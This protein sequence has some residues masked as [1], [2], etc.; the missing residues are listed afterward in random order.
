MNSCSIEVDGMDARAWHEVLTRFGDASIDQSVAYAGARWPS[1]HLSHLIVRRNA[2]LA[3]AA[4]VVIWR[5]PF[6]RARFGLVKF[7][8]LWRPAGERA[9]VADLR[10]IVAALHRE[11]VAEQGILLRVIPRPDAPDFPAISDALTSGGFHLETRDP[12]PDRYLVDLAPPLEAIEAGLHASWRRHLHRARRHAP[13]V[14]VVNGEDGLARFMS[15]Y[16][17]MRARKDF[18]DTSGIETLPALC[19]DATDA[20][21]PRIF[22]LQEGNADVAGAAVTALGDT[23]MCLFAAT[24]SRALALSAGYLIHWRVIEWLKTHAPACRWYDLGGDCGNEGLRQ[25]KRG[26]VGSTGQAAPLPGSFEASPGWEADI[27]VHSALR[28]RDVLGGLRARIRHP[29]HVAG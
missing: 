27:A 28:A 2:R 14:T 18:R 24:G 5:I 19:T 10:A 13:A 22:L 15:L 29:A 9:D 4:Q 16:A 8:P 12:H 21:R 23:A 17:E 7:G 6:V 20:I 11:Y 3:A 26:L 1:A 25:F